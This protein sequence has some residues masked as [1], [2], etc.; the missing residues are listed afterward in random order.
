MTPATRLTP[1][2]RT[3]FGAPPDRQ[4]ECPS[5]DVR[6]VVRLDWERDR[7][8]AERIRAGD[9][10]AFSKMYETS[11]ES[12][13]RFILKRIREPNDAEDLTQET[14]VQAYRSIGNF[15]SRS[16]LLTWLLGI[17]RYTTLHFYRSSGR[18]MT[19]FHA[20][21][22]GPAPAWEARTALQVEAILTLDRCCEVLDHSCSKESQSIFKLRYGASMSVRDIARGIGKSPNAVKASLQRSRQ[23]LQHGLGITGAGER[24][25]FSARRGDAAS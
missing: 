16:S 21:E 7:E 8:L 2:N 25:E 13:Y 10:D 24:I 9:R 11:R 23:A 19:A 14:F 1:T 4:S 17:A 20:V 15:E 18:W 5:H 12:V 3:D 22:V 6:R